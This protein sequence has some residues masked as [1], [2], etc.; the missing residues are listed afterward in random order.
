VARKKKHLLPHPHPPLRPRLPLKP[1][2]LPLLPPHQL[3]TQL[4]LPLPQHLLPPR[5]LLL[6]KPR[7][8]EPDW[9]RATPGGMTAATTRRWR[10]LFFVRHPSGWC[11][12]CA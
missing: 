2:P 4:L 5:L 3:P 10:V 6:K 8:P 1:H 12:A 7:S 9:V 11:H